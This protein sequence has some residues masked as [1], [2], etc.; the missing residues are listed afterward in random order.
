[1]EKDYSNWDIW[2]DTDTAKIVGVVYEHSGWHIYLPSTLTGTYYVKSALSRALSLIN[3]VS[4]VD[5]ITFKYEG[6]VIKLEK[7]SEG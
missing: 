6:A 4:E 7:R 2:H 5:E 1:M 3:A